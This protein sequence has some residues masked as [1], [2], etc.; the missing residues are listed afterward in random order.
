MDIGLYWHGQNFVDRTKIRPP[1]QRKPN[2]LGKANI[3]S[4]NL[5]LHPNMPK[6]FV[7]QEER[8]FEVVLVQLA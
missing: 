6:V 8:Q 3:W 7:G 2:W 4:N 5:G 1:T